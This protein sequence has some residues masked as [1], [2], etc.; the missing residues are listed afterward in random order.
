MVDMG[1]AYD[2]DLK[3]I[4]SNGVLETDEGVSEKT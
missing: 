3:N 4:E 1:Y 2:D